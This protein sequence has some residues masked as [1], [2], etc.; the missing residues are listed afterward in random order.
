MRRSFFAVLI[1]S[2]VLVS[3]LVV[4]AV[5]AGDDDIPGVPFTLGGTVS[6]TVGAANTDDVYAVTLV[7]GEQVHVRCDPGS[8]AGSGGSFKLLTPGVTSLSL[9][10]DHIGMNYTLSGGSYVRMWADFDYTPAKSGT[11]Y[12]W[13]SW[14]KGVL[15]YSI[16]V[17][18]TSQATL[19]LA[20][21]SDDIPGTRVGAGTV[22]GV[23][24]TNVDENDV[25][26][27][28]LA[29]GRAVTI[30]L[31][32]LAS[33]TG[34]MSLLDPST[35]SIA[36]RY[37]HRIGDRVGTTSGD[38][39]EIH[40]TPTSSATYYILVE[41]GGVLYA[42]NFPY[43]LTITETGGA[44]AGFADVAASPYEAAIHELAD[45]E[46]ITGYEDGTFRPNNPV[47]RQQFA[48]MIVKALGL[49]VTGAEVCPFA[50]VAAQTGADPFYPSKY[51]AV[52]AAHG[53]TAGKTA[54]TFAPGENITHQQLI[55]MVARAARLA[56][57]PGDF[58]PDFTAAQFS[59]EEHYQNA[60][61]AA[62]AGL[63]N[64]LQGVPSH[65]RSTA[66]T[67]G[68][69]AQILYNLLQRQ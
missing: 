17:T 28:S 24:S 4:P 51:V 5:A 68:Q 67:R 8:A 16:T 41:C 23:V 6:G 33:S 55:T 21:E 58:T 9:A 13:V 40:Y 22:T 54:T 65:E 12:L 27:I 3:L 11:Y 64:G 56:D 42:K 10:S 62:Y 34:Y 49:A 69:C 26:A 50:D 38:T 43:R 47:T 37:S 45:R 7:A 61:K 48:K 59:L 44:P 2:L 29:A 18:R 35:P 32:A 63:L 30:R 46:I 15:N 60:R 52:C 66:S 39:A 19:D 20:A 36:K 14:T 1:T 25:Y 53:I 31:T 57:P